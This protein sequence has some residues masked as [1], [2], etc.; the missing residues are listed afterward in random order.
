MENQPFQQTDN[1]IGKEIGRHK[2]SDLKSKIPELLTDL[3]KKQIE[4]YENRHNQTKQNSQ[5]LHDY[6]EMI[7]RPKVKTEIKIDVNELFTVFKNT[8][9]DLNGKKF[10]LNDVT[11]EN[12]APFLYYFSK[13]EKF[14]KCKNLSNLSKPSF[15]KG[16]LVIGDFGNGKTS[17]FKTFEKIFKNIPGYIFTGYS[18][19]HVVVEYEKCTDDIL[20]KEFEQKMFK[21]KRYFDDVKT[22]RT[23]SNYGKVNIFKEILE[24]RYNQKSLTY[25]SCNY[26]EGF[27]NDINEALSE[28]GEKYGGRVYDRLFEMF[29]IIEFKG[30]SFRI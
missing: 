23:A 4:I 30:K 25:I 7:N 10:E 28:F 16:L 5:Y 15:D 19:N 13:N 18:A 21:G 20:R 3:E 1:L 27:P 14:F 24:E 22:E 17:V 11:R 26:K 2:Y 8:F 6:F 29:N 12:I 9:L